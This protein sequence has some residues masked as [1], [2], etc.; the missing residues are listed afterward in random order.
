MSGFETP[1][2]TYDVLDKWDSPSW[3]DQTRA[4]V[5]QRLEE[6][7]PRR[8]LS[9][10][11]WTLL[12]AIVARLIPQP[13]REIPVP[14]VPWIDDML[15]RN[16]G[17][18][19]RYADMPPMRDAWSQGLDAIAAEAVNRHGRSFEELSEEDQ[20]EL[21]KNV[22]HNRVEARN[23]E[24]LSAGGFFLQHLLKETVGIYYSHPSAWSEI[25]YGGPA[26]PRGY[27]RLGFD[28]RDPW[29]A[30]EGSTGA[31]HA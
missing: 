7:P 5:R 4:A 13:D 28:E 14:I 8:F 10:E 19:Y 17:P 12:E 29:E 27:A 22:Q 20:D 11:Q 2:P 30:K 24:G 1:Y 18:G 9:K 31:E 23:W 25:G 16:H 3:N 21:L 6:V 26:S 15:H